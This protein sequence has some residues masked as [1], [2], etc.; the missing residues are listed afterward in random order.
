MRPAVILTVLALSIYLFGQGGGLPQK[1]SLP[2]DKPQAAATLQ[3]MVVRAADGT[4]LKKAEVTLFSTDSD[5]RG[6]SAAATTGMDGRFAFSNLQPG[7]YQI[8]A[9]RN[10][11]VRAQYGQPAPNASGTP[12]TL[13][14]GQTVKD[15]LIR[16]NAAAVISGRVVDE[17]GEAMQ[18]VRVQV[19]RWVYRNGGRQLTPAGGAGSTNDLGEYRVSGLPPGRYIVSAFLF[20]ARPFRGDGNIQ[21]ST[22]DS[23]GADERYAPVFYPNVLDGGQAVPVPVRAGEEVPSINFRMTPVITVHV[24]GTLR[25]STGE[26]AAN[27]MVRLVPRSGVLQPMR[28]GNSTNERGAF[29]IDG[30]TPG[31]YLLLAVAD[32]TV[33]YIANVSR[34]SGGNS[35]SLA[36]EWL[37]QDIEVAGS[38]VETSTVLQ[39]A[40]EMRGQVRLEAGADLSGVTPRI[41]L[42]SRNVGERGAAVTLNKDMTF[43][44]PNVFGGEYSLNISGLPQ[45]VYVKSARAGDEDL[46]ENGLRVQGRVA[47][48]DIVLSGAA[49]HI[50]GNAV[51]DQ[52]QALASA[53]IILAPDRRSR[54]DLYK[55]VTADA[56]GHFSL[57]GIAPGSYK[58]FAF[59]SVDEGAWLDPD[60]I[61]AFEDFGHAVSVGESSNLTQD[62]R[63]IPGLRQSQ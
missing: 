6:R 28:R 25:T 53:R 15:V 63:T 38:D 1:K 2:S 61:A 19:M 34:A 40:V 41:S 55:V 47:P 42:N 36:S 33:R 30:V 8:T 22:E 48:I 23:G 45:N 54:Y 18:N 16:L 24:R 56:A 3:G 29:D 60:F 39:P 21:V 35:P 59:E 57:R 37:R 7:R 49:G 31:S 44:A 46:L 43:S 32:E 10:G 52:R 27:V 4:P 12:I 9:T 58:L 51:D 5:D 11:Y 50:E 13:A 14:A 20:R 26:P 62:V 17:D